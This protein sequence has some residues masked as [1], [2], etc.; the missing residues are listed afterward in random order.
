MRTGLMRFSLAAMLVLAVGAAAACGSSNKNSGSSG[1]GGGA[2]ASI[3]GAGS[4][5]AA[6]IYQQWGNALKSQ[7]LTVNYQPVGSGAGVAQLAAGTVDF[8]ASDPSLTPDDRKTFKKGEAAQIPMAFGAITVSYNLS[9][10]QKGLKLDGA[11]IAD[12]FLGKITKWNAP[13]IAKLNPGV[14][15]PG[16]AITVVHRSDESGT[17]KG[18]TTFLA[19]YS[20]E[21]KSK[22]GVDKTVKWPTGTGAKGNDG[23]AAGVK[24]QKGAIGYVEEAYA[25]QNNFTTASVKNKAG[26][27]VEPT[28]ASTTAAGEGITVPADLG[29]GI[30]DAANPKA[31]PIASQTFVLVYKD[32]CKAGVAKGTASGVK[33]FVDYGLGEGQNVLGQLQY[34]KLPAAVLTKAKAAAGTLQCNGSPLT[35]G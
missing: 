35:G 4:T 17:T 13:A 25:L 20:P 14:K 23:V 7:N 26:Q 27:F 5:F 3:N 29:I 33:R 6:P 24:Q 16:D 11:T 10:V 34:A 21:W 28:L 8:G 15:L 32:M 9:G 1:S 12:I 19:A 2:T 31:Y 22:V 30:I 18:F